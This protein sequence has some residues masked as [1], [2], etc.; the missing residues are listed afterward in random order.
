MPEDYC[1]AKGQWKIWFKRTVGLTHHI[2]IS[3][4]QVNWFSEFYHYRTRVMQQETRLKYSLFTS[5]LLWKRRKYYG[6]S[7]NNT[8]RSGQYSE[9]LRWPDDW[10][11]W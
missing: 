10:R 2:D 7:R 3:V 5:L 9:W 6:G 11:T 8:K 1:R 4:S